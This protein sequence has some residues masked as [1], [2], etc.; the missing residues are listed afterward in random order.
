MDARDLN[1]RREATAAHG[2]RSSGSRTRDVEARIPVVMPLYQGAR[3][4]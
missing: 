4:P 3:K 2:Q 1:R